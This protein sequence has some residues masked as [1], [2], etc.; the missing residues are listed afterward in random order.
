MNNLAE[1][2]GWVRT[3]QS[4]TPWF[5][6]WKELFLLAPG[7]PVGAD[8]VSQIADPQSIQG[9]TAANVIKRSTPDSNALE[10]LRKL[11][12]SP[13]SSIRWRSA[14]ALGAFPDDQNARALL[15]VLTEDPYAWARYG[16]VRSLVEQASLTGPGEL[17]NRIIKS[18]VDQVALI[19]NDE[20]LRLE[21]QRC[22]EVEPVPEMWA[23]SLDPLL[24]ALWDGSFGELQ[25]YWE[26]LANKLEVQEHSAPA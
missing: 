18:L 8:F 14:H 12:N 17:R 16:A 2:Q 4:S 9:W 15:E 7:S 13:T 24:T 11:L 21:L 25:L 5:L 6:T 10:A 26:R 20:R 22:L 19:L 1:L 23:T 3:H